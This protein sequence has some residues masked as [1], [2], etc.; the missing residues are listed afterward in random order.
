MWSYHLCNTSRCTC[1]LAN[2]SSDLFIQDVEQIS[3]T[4]PDY[5]HRYP[6]Q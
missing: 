2:P 5:Y 3:K 1:I 4:N 6:N